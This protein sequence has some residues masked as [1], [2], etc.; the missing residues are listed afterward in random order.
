MGAPNKGLAHK[1]LSISLTEE[2]DLAVIELRKQKEYCRCS[3]VE[4]IRVLMEAGAKAIAA[5]RQDSGEI[6]I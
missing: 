4:C 3:Y 1:R 2:L 6:T 5:R